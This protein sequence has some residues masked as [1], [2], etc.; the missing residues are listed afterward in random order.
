MSA[1]DTGLAALGLAKRGLS[2]FPLHSPRSGGG[3]TCVLDLECKNPAKHPRNQHG[4]TEA[5]SD[6]DRVVE[7]WRRWP[8]ANVGIATGPVSGFF[9]LDLDLRHGGQQSLDRLEAENGKLPRTVQVRTGSGGFHWWFRWPEGCDIRNSAGRIGPGLDI[10]GDGGSIVAPPSLHAFGQRYA[11]IGGH[12]LADAPAW[13]LA[14]AV[15]SCDADRPKTDWAAFV[16]NPIGDGQRNTEMTR[17]AGVLLRKLDPHL[18]LE[19]LLSFNATRC[20]PPLPER[21]VMAIAESIAT[22]ELRRRAR[23][24]AA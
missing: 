24:N 20:V 14:L 10:R 15:G 8:T 17:L 11:W 13:L 6:P 12:D 4:V 1:P 21:E 9:A 16:R 5:T 23:E 2:V 22:R 7:W 19:L 18:A 3:C